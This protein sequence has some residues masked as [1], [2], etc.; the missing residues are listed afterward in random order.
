MLH[1]HDLDHVQVGLL[2]GLVDGE[3]RIDDGRRQ[4]LSKARAKLCGEG[5]PGDR[6]EELAV[7]IAGELKLVE[8]LQRVSRRSGAPGLGWASQSQPSATRS[9]QSR[10]HR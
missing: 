7:D 3:D 10:S 9:W 5:G 6:E 8:E 2:G 1:L 4:A